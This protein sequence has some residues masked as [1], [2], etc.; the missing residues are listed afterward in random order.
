M[1]RGGE[2]FM[3]HTQD[4]QHRM[5]FENMFMAKPQPCPSPDRGI[6]PG[7]YLI[8]SN[9][10]LEESYV[11]CSLESKRLTRLN[12]KRHIPR[13]ET[14]LILGPARRANAFR[15]SVQQEETAT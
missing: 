12:I 2:G 1:A 6:T 3:R 13:V 9:P 10:P 11:I 14:P 4:G 15:A 8:L 7:N 5:D